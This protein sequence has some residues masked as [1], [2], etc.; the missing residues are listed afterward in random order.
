MPWLGEVPK[1]W[2]FRRAKY[3]FRESDDR[4]TTGEEELLSV[5]HLTGVT[6]RST[7]NINMFMAESNVGYKVCR[8]NDVVI[9]T[10]WAWMAALGVARQWGIASPS[11]AVYRPLP[12]VGLEPTYVDRLLRTPAYA[13]E[14]LCASTGVNTSRLR[15][16]PERFLTIPILRPPAVEQAAIVRFLNH[17]DR[18]I[19][20]YI[21]AKRKLIRLLEEQKRAIIDHVVA[22]GLDPSVR[23]RPSSVEWL[24]DVPEDWQV[25]R[26]KA[27]ASRVTSG[28]RGWSDFAADSGALFIRIGNLTRA[29]IDLDLENIVR[30]RLPAHVLGE[31]ARTRVQCDDVLLSITAFIGSVA[32]V[33]PGLEEAYVSQHV[34]CC[35]LWERCANPRWVAWVLLSRVGQTHGQLSMYGGTKQGLSLDDVKNHVVLLPPRDLQDRLVEWIELKSERLSAGIGST[36]QE[37]ALLREYRTRLIADVVTGKLDVREAAAR[38]PEE[39][40][41]SEPIDVVEAAGDAGDP[42]VDDAD[43]VLEEAEA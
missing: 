8:P 12:G 28:S 29:S 21:S 37:I 38:L 33:P 36:K 35:R 6:P 14:Y 20:R 23:L 22:R 26:L 39:A 17:V 42:D 18:R 5:S 32:V 3:F 43:E 16:Y 25:V 41:E 9:N 15:L 2:D 31:A 34:A 13:S 7:K 27:L 24:G 1:H 10:M 4:S 19:R 30:L 40:G 11:Y